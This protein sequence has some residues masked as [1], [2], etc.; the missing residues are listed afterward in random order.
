MQLKKCKREMPSP[1]DGESSGI[2]CESCLV[3]ECSVSVCVHSEVST[4]LV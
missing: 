3:V 1:E 4:S 2:E